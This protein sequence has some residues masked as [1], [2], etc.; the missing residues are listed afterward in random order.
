MTGVQTCALPISKQLKETNKL[1]ID[2]LV[3]SDRQLSAIPEADMIKAVAQQLKI[4]EDN[5]KIAQGE[6][7]TLQKLYDE[8]VKATNHKQNELDRLFHN[9]NDE[10]LIAHQ[11]RRILEHTKEV[12]HTLGLYRK[13]LIEKHIA[14][15]EALI[16]ESFTA[17]IRKNDL[18]KIGRAHV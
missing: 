4:A 14:R 17:L 16:Q 13:A 7:N 15:L 6:N 3:I 1:L 8:T 9:A 5:S 2:E 10:Q 18:V 11:D 12:R